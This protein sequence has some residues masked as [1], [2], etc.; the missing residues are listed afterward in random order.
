MVF[1]LLKEVY[2]STQKN[3]YFDKQDMMANFSGAVA[4]KVTIAIPL[5]LKKKDTRL[6][7]Q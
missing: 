1:G 5:N 7:K 6:T 3:K 2:D 4:F